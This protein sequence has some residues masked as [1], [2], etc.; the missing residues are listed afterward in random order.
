MGRIQTREGKIRGEHK[1]V[2]HLGTTA[3]PSLLWTT[4][5]T[6]KIQVGATVFTHGTHRLWSRRRTSEAVTGSFPSRSSTWSQPK[7]IVEI[8]WAVKSSRWGGG[9]ILPF[10]FGSFCP[11]IWHSR[12][13]CFACS[14]LFFVYISSLYISVWSSVRDDHLLSVCLSSQPRCTFFFHFNL[15]PKP[16]RKSRVWSLPSGNSLTEFIFYI[17]S[18]RSGYWGRALKE[19]DPAF[20][21]CDL[22]VLSL[23]SQDAHLGH[24]LKSAKKK[25]RA[26]S[27]WG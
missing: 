16:L 27:L 11:V 2:F 7:Q 9:E 8:S 13:K 19:P 12:A 23:K 5:Q 18:T 22:T 14:H 25:V 6:G 3:S 1:E 4:D 21:S 20:V 24:N 15:I 10:R 17:S 26:F